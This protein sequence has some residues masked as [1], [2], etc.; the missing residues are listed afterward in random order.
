MAKSDRVYSTPPTSSSVETECRATA[1]HYFANRH[2]FEIAGRA[3]LR[4]S[5]MRANR[6]PRLRLVRVEQGAQ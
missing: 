3:H 2:R 6:M 1:L 4:P 5:P